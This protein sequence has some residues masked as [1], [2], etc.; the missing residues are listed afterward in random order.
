M[1]KEHAWP[2]LPALAAWEDTC[3]ALH[4]WTQVVGK[5]RLAQTPLVNHWWNVPLYVTARGLTT[6]AMPCGKEYFHIDFD[7]IGQE[8]RVGTSRGAARAFALQSMSVADFYGR[9]MA[10]LGELDIDTQIWPVPVELETATPFEE[11]T[12]R[13]AY[14]P[15][16]ARR[17]WRA[18]LQVDR[19]FRV[20]RARFLGKVSPVHFFWGAFDLAVTRFSGREAPPH[21][22]GIPNVGDFV[23]RE[24]YSH[25]VSSAGFWP[26]NG[27]GEAAFYAYAYPDPD[28]FSA[29][30]VQPA[31]AYF[32]EDLGE[33]VLPYAA[34]QTA[35]DPD[36]ALLA[37]LQTTYE[38]AAEL[39]G[40][41][42][43]ALERAG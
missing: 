32:D 38:A 2:A 4:L 40:W 28:G 29:W 43:K 30:D 39:A 10:V 9:V 7:F 23:M 19:V 35:D 26:G 3:T 41:D 37:F 22:G 33:F 25:E 34:V 6:S 12:E 31:A 15:D 1:I 20:F 24:A 27:L 36:G 16:A 11:N 42:R 5:V 14:E 8:L 21:P 13:V 17:F 18:L